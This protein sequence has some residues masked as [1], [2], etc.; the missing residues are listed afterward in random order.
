MKTMK[1]K[2]ILSLV[3]AVIGSL[4]LVGSTA[5]A[6]TTN[7][8]PFDTEG[9]FTNDLSAIRLYGWWSSAQSW[10]VSWTAGPTNQWDATLDANGIP[11]SGSLRQYYELS[12]DPGAFQQNFDFVNLVTDASRNHGPINFFSD[13]SYCALDVRF[14]PGSPVST[15]GNFGEYLMI[16]ITLRTNIDLTTTEDWDDVF[17]LNPNPA[18]AGRWV[19]YQGTAAARQTNVVAFFTGLQGNGYTNGPIIANVDN[20][21][22]YTATAAPSTNLIVY[23]FNTEGEFT[24]DLAAIRLYGWWSSA[25]SWVLSWTAMPTN[26]YD[27]FRDANNASGS[28]SL[29]QHYD[30]PSVNPGDFQQAFD[31]VNLVTDTNL[32]NY[33]PINFFRDFAFCALDARFDPSSTLSTNGNYGEYLLIAITLR[34]NIDLTTTEDWDDVFRLN[35]SAADAGQWVTYQGAAVARQTNVVAFFTGLQGTGYTGPILANVDNLRFLSPPAPPPALTIQRSAP[36]LEMVP[37]P[38]PARPDAG[39]FVVSTATQFATP[40][41]SWMAYPDSGTAG[42]TPVSYALTISQFPDAAHS[43]FVA[44]M[45]LAPELTIPEGWRTHPEISLPHAMYLTI[46]NNSDGTATA[47]LVYKVN[48]ADSNNLWTALGTLGS[49]SPVGTW[50]LTLNNTNVQ[51]KAPNASVVNSSIT[52][53][54]VALF[55]DG[56]TPLRVWVGVQPRVA[57]NFNQMAVFTSFNVSYVDSITGVNVV[58]NETWTSD[59]QANWAEATDCVG[60]LPRPLNTI[61]R[62]N[63]PGPATGFALE[64]NTVLPG[65][66][67]SWTVTGFPVGTSNSK[68]VSFVPS[69]SAPNPNNFYRLHKP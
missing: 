5:S 68:K 30:W 19:R 39:P 8:Y 33:G 52:D 37:A 60:I 32:S 51:L 9:E 16:A 35:P 67:G 7:L 64:Q 46:T 62:L 44:H 36:G 34:T 57:A 53:T 42:P 17:R 13:Y 2:R 48:A 15:N 18:D 31:M 61:Y 28:G 69:S 38:T 58:T 55:N 50:T 26:E 4:L 12:T 20:L 47:S 45:I 59:Y 25:Q 56:F 6:Q 3:S 43:N 49:P 1:T 41:L 10:V 29:R 54:D 66:P 14:D 21:R 22:F 40:L 11:S 27:F 24:N 23:P 65:A 63:W